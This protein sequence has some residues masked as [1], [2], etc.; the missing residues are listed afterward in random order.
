MWDLIKDF[1]TLAFIIY[2][3]GIFVDLTWSD[4]NSRRGRRR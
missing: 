2:C 1:A 4:K 3:G